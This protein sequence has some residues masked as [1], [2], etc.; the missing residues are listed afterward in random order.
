[1]ARRPAIPAGPDD[2][3]LG[4][5]RQALACSGIFEPLQLQLRAIQAEP[6][7][8]GRGL[9]STVIRSHLEWSVDAP[10]QPGSVIIKLRSAD[11]KTA[12]LARLVRLY[13]HEYLFYQR[14]QPFAGIRS[15]EL[16]YGGFTNRVTGSCW[17]WKTWPLWNQ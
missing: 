3:T 11:R 14:I 10:K 9:L 8:S 6:V 4:W 7:G 5:L 12:R 1:M 13:R 2:I 15:P 16:L 17:F